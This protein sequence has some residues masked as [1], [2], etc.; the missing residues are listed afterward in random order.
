MGV[1]RTEANRYIR[2]KQLASEEGGDVATIKAQL[3]A[4]NDQ[5]FQFA[6]DSVSGK[7]GYIVDVGGTE[8]FIPFSSGGGASTVYLD[9][10]LIMDTSTYKKAD[11][12]TTLT[13]DTWIFCRFVDGN[14]TFYGVVLWDGPG[15]YG[16][17]AKGLSGDTYT[18]TIAADYAQGNNISGSYRDMYLDIVALDYPL[19]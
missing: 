12:S 1:T 4:D 15:N 10:G 16:F 17:R 19:T 2:L 11:F 13:A 7:Y 18:I 3:V 8:T 5:P 9:H 6:Y 14:D